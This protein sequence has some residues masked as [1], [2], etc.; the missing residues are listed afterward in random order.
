LHWL[1]I[2]QKA[3][4]RALAENGTYLVIA[5]AFKSDG[6]SKAFEI[7]YRLNIPSDVTGPTCQLALVGSLGVSAVGDLSARTQIIYDSAS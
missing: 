6:S 2:R 1:P 7:E 3:G 4:R 5:Y